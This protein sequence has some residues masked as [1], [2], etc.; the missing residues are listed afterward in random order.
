[1]IMD[2]IE[3]KLQLLVVDDDASM[4][5][6]IGATLSKEFVESH[7][8]TVTIE[9]TLVWGLAAKGD[10]DI[11][12]TDMDMP[13]INGFKLLKQL[14]QINPLT[15]VIF[16]TAHPTMDAAK[17]AFSLGADEFL[18]KPVN[19]RDLCNSVRYLSSRINRWKTE[20]IST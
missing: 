13:Q 8:L 11:C 15:Q 6:L 3:R 2:S 17:S 7:D 19:L 12:V 16:L 14:K 18:P 10:V 4:A 20:L 1:M 9:P 5:K